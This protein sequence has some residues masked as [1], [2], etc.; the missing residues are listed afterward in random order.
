MISPTA[1]TTIAFIQRTVSRIFINHYVGIYPFIFNFFFFFLFRRTKTC[2]SLVLHIWSYGQLN[3]WRQCLGC[4]THTVV[5]QGPV[6]V[7][8]HVRVNCED[9]RA[10][11]NTTFNVWNYQRCFQFKSVTQR[12]YNNIYK[13]TYNNFFF[14]IGVWTIYCVHASRIFFFDFCMYYSTDRTI[15]LFFFPL[16][17]SC[18]PGIVLSDHFIQS[19][20]SENNRRCPN[21]YISWRH[22]YTKGTTTE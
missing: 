21:T 2:T 8:M 14:P 11:Q 22:G 16:S 6:P 13:T 5:S 12:A 10:T 1:I 17:I 18:L 7:R 19:G 20:A 15:S 4:E 3:T 9:T